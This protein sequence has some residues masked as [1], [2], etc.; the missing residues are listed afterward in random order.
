MSGISSLPSGPTSWPRWSSSPAPAR[1]G[2]PRSPG[3]SCGRRVRDLP[4][5]GQPRGPRRDPGRPLARR[6]GARRAGRAAQ[7]ARLEGLAQGRVRQ[8]PGAPAIPRDRQRP[9]R[10]IPARRRFAPGALPPLPAPPLLATRR[11]PPAGPR[12]RYHRGGSSISR[13]RAT[14]RPRQALLQSGVSRSRSSHSPRAP[15]AAGRRRGSTGS[16]ARTS[17]TSR[18]SAICPSLQ[19]LADLLPD[20]SARSSRSTRSA[21]TS[22]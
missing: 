6:H 17:A 10:H 5:L 1:S 3:A 18:P 11:P 13:R 9:A 12:E 22:R 14:A 16:S 15:C 7:V 21:R 8:A 2:R 19:L 20:K 4:Q